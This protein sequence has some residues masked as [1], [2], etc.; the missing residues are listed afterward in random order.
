VIEAELVSQY[1]IVLDRIWSIT[2]Y[3]SSVSFGLI[4]VAYFAA[5]KL[6]RS[7]L[8]SLTTM[9]TV[10]TFWIFL[11]LARNTLWQRSI[12]QD[13]QDLANGGITLT[14]YASE[15]VQVVAAPSFVYAILP[16]VIYMG[17]YFASMTYLIYTYRRKNAANP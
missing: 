11:A 2:Q 15:L 14:S 9:Y 3:W 5:H 10:Y 16:I 13:L 6:N 4:V 17:L 8:A 7:L 1:S 12:A